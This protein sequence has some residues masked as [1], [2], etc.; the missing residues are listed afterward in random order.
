MKGVLRSGALWL[1]A[2]T[3][4]A[5]P[6]WATSASAGRTAQAASN[7]AR[8]AGSGNLW[9]DP[10]GGS[11]TRQARPGPYVDARACGGLQAAANAAASGDVILIKDGTYGGERL[12]GSKTLTFRGV[13][14]GRPSFGQIVTSASNQTLRHVLVENRDDQPTPACG[15]FV[16][17]YTLFAC[18]AHETFDDVIVDALHHPAG[19]SERK[20]GIEATDG[21]TGLVFRN[22]EIRGV[23]DSKGFQGGAA[24]MLFENNVFHDITLTASGSAA[25]VHNECAYITGGTGQTWRRNRFLFC[26]VMAMFFANFIGGPPFTG[27]TIE[28]NV[29]THSVNDGGSWHEGS[30]FVIPN[31]AGGQNQVTGWVIRYNTFEVPP[32]FGSTPGTGDDNGSAK[33]YGNLGADG[34]CKAPEWTYSYN[35]GETC[36]GTGEV[37]VTRATNDRSHPTQAPFYVGA[38]TGDFHLRP[39]SPAVN[40]GDPASFPVT[41][42]DGGNRPLAAAPDAGAYEY[43]TGVLALGGLDS[44]A[45]TQR[46][47]A[48]TIREFEQKNAANLLLTLGNNDYTRGRSFSAAWQSAFS[49]L[50]QARVK[51]AGTLGNRDV[52][53]RGGRYQFATLGMPAAYY[54]RRLRD[55]EVIVLDS[56]AVNAAQ[57]RWLEQTL[58]QEADLFRVIV[59]NHSP[60]SCGGSAGDAAMRN[61]WVPLFKRYG[62][63]L[64]LSGH[65]PNYQRFTVGGVT[66]VAG[67]VGAATN[68]KPCLTTRVAH[69][70][71]KLAS[72]FVYLRVDATGAHVSSVGLSGKTIDTFSVK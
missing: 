31:G 34:D 28:N 68:V 30:S 1:V 62:V 71:A 35:V 65:D 66:Y 9:V 2:S 20:G 33:Y 40:R 60:F 32:D 17:D 18:G 26:P 50:G 56:N 41:D 39:G 27:V 4:L 63:H 58:R 16:L 21:A 11:C 42:V 8:A 3:L 64:V 61:L 12:S 59:L 36:H 24:N 57:T 7:V 48:A 49:W 43:G 5:V 53:I 10:N 47:V 6:F 29:F 51:V 25:G 67:T 19:D 22:G 55:V 14:P 46:R 23:Q 45:D 15:N 72:A 37:S 54:V 13:G 70:T 44:S 52:Q 38:A 69:R